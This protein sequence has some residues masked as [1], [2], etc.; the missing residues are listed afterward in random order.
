[1]QTEPQR[2]FVDAPAPQQ[3][4]QAQQATARCHDPVAPPAT[5][6]PAPTPS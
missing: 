4:P 5:S 3:E 2:E 1:V 6:Q